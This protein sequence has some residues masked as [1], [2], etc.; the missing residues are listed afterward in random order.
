MRI[1]LRTWLGLSL[2][3]LSLLV[4]TT[5][6]AQANGAPIVEAMGHEV[7]F[8]ESLRFHLT[9]SSSADITSAVLAYFTT[10]NQA[11]TVERL[12]FTPAHRVELS[13]EIDLV[14]HPLEPFVEIEY[15]WMVGDADGRQLTIEHESFPYEDTRFGK[16]QSLEGQRVEV[17]WYDGDAAFGSLALGVADQAVDRIRE[18]IEPSLA[19]SE[20][21]DLYLYAN[22]TDLAP[23]LPATG[24]EWMVGHAYPELQVALAAIPPGPESASTMRWLIPH[25]LT[26]LLLYEAMGSSYERL[27]PWLNE[28]LAVVGE[29]VPDPDEEVVLGRAFQGG[30]LLSLE[31]LCYSFPRWDDRVH[32]AYAQSA[33]VVRYIQENY[34]HSAVGRLVEAYGDGLSCRSGVRRA[35]GI[36][37]GSLESQWRE[38]LGVRPQGAVFVRQ[39]MP[40]LL[41]VLVSLPLLLLAA[42]PLAIRRAG[43]RRERL[44]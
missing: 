26:H 30:Q 3:C 27:P 25:E 18:M 16:W 15:R 24:R 32:L 10:H 36:S 40:W 28:G 7:R 23:A 8:G 43:Q 31:S 21:F 4:A 33:S 14:H 6:L 12:D 17:H 19:L 20:T 38:S 44:L 5:V 22:E 1:Q 29:Q 39:A 2:T 41:L 35:L 11:M 34:G 37:L 9:V 42:R 13:H